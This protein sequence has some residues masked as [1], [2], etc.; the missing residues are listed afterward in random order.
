[1]APSFYG[2]M[3]SY[4]HTDHRFIAT[5]IIH[6]CGEDQIAAAPSCLLEQFAGDHNYHVLSELVEK[7]I[8]GGASSTR[9]LHML[10]YGGYDN[11]IAENLLEKR[12]WVD[13]G[14]Y[15]ALHACVQ[16]DA[17]K[18]CRLLLDHGMDFEQYQTWAA[19]H[20]GCV[21]ADTLQELEAHWQELTEQRQNAVP[22]MGGM[23]LG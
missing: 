8:S 15:S 18:V 22:R 23:E 5:Q 10:T 7:G 17:V 13:P 4:A 3:A 2:E 19:T 1:M 6:Q 14:D 16:N 21:P 20:Q 11:W 12:M 9:T